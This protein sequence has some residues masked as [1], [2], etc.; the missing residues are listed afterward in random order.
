ML[1]DGFLV[2]KQ[3]EKEQLALHWLDMGQDQEYGKAEES[4]FHC[5]LVE[6]FKGCL[7]YGVV[8]PELDGRRSI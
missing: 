2:E 8:L 4:S 3:K 6:K 7:V 5:E 1:F